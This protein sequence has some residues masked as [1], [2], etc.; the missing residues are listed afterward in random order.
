MGFTDVARHLETRRQA[1]GPARSEGVLAA[2]KEELYDLEKDPNE[3]KNLAS[4][5]ASA[6][7]LT[8]LRAKL[9]DWRKK[10]NDPWLVK[11]Q[12]E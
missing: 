2:P 5:P 9:A 12:H 1:D 7:I 10:T 8:E 6:K 11:D 4:D 3:L